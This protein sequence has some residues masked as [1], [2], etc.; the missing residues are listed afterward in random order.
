V[1]PVGPPALCC[2]PLQTWTP[3]CA[4]LVYAAVAYQREA[5]GNSGAPPASCPLPV[6]LTKRADFRLRSETHWLLTTMGID[7]DLLTFLDEVRYHPG[8]KEEREREGGR[9]EGEGGRKTEEGEGDRGRIESG[10]KREKEERKDMTR[11]KAD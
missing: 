7:V 10:R 2:P 11:P 8:E 1:L 3:Q 9:G 4:S 6:L 5:S